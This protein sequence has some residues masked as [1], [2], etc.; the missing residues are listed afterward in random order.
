MINYDIPWNP[1]RVIQRVGRINRI[2]K[3]VFDELYIFNFFPSEQGA[4]YIIVAQV[5]R[6]QGAVE[7]VGP[8]MKARSRLQTALF[9]PVV[10]DLKSPICA[11]RGFRCVDDTIHPRKGRP[12]GAP[13]LESVQGG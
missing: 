13:G 4:T 6:H 2:G 9:P 7:E 1:T 10:L 3:K 5:H 8:Y 12:F 11:K